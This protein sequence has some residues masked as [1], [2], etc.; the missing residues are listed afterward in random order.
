M[1][2]RN[3]TQSLAGATFGILGHPAKNRM[4]TAENSALSCTIEAGQW[5]DEAR[6]MASPPS[7]APYG[8]SVM[9]WT[10]FQ[11]LPFEQRLEKVHAAGYRNV[12]LVRE[13]HGW[14][15]SD[16]ARVNRRR[17]LLG[18]RFDAMSGLRNGLANP[19]DRP[20]MLAEVRQVLATM[21]LLGCPALILLSGNRVPGIPRALQHA[22][23]IEGLKQAAGLIEGRQIA[24]EPVR[25]LIEN[26]DPEEN[27]HYYLHSGR[28]GFAI[29]RAVN[30]P[31]VQMLYDLYHEQ[32]AEGNLI[33]KLQ[34]NLPLLGLVHIADVPGR[35][36]PGTGEIHFRNI[37]RTLT[38]LG[39]D[40][41][42]AMEFL[43]L[44]EPVEQLRRAGQEA[45]RGGT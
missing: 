15:R 34:K 12:E 44:G 33:E 8:L 38:A 2:R 27:P 10:V 45:L 7:R 5:D 35:H 14:S 21:E 3:F 26:I 37:Y 25:L 42:V 43:P 23:C 20:A 39:Y 40:R 6:K 36:Q 16:F 31:Q 32:V 4:F 17:R 1:H 41:K 22:S 11:N 19:Q 29:V 18:I 13:Y 24:G 28:E 9:L 30:H